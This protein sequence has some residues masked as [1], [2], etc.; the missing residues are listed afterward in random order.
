[1]VNVLSKIL[2]DPNERVTKKFQPIV[3]E[4]T[5]FGDKYLKFSGI[6]LCDM[7]RIFVLRGRFQLRLGPQLFLKALHLIRV[8]CEYYLVLPGLFDGEMEDFV[9]QRILIFNV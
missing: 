3:E 2:G 4:T 7:S 1:M 5:F 9:D 6:F 8:L